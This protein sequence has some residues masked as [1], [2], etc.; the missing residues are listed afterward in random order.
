M[1]AI[2]IIGEIGVDM[3]AFLSVR[4]FCS[5]AGVVPANNESA[6]KKKSVRCA[7]AGVYI[8]P[9]MVQVAHAA[10]KS[11]KC[12]YFGVRYNQIARRRGKKKAIIAVAHMM[13]VCIFH[14]L[15]RNEDFKPELYTLPNN[16]KP[17]ARP[18]LTLDTA[19]KLLES[20]GATIVM[21]EVIPIVASG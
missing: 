11:K 2:A 3:S 1:T 18:R 17:M 5:W 12:P 8:K 10:V 19:R 7:R 14:V 9:L 20:H 4:H 6:G 15:A 16:K 13:L 21:P